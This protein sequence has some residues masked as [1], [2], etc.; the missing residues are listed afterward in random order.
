[1]CRYRKVPQPS[2]GRSGGIP[3][4]QGIL[5]VILNIFQQS[6]ELIKTYRAVGIHRGCMDS[7]TDTL[8]L[9]NKTVIRMTTDKSC[10]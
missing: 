3:T 2:H 7:K 8:G 6:V 1:M 5:H 4:R 9:V 10:N